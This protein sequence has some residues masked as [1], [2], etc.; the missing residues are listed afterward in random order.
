MICCFTPTVAPV[1]EMFIPLSIHLYPGS[2]KNF[3]WI[4]YLQTVSSN[5]SFANTPKCVPPSKSTLLL[6][7]NLCWEHWLFI[8]V[9]SHCALWIYSACM[10]TE[11][12]SSTLS[13][14][15]VPP[16]RRVWVLTLIVGKYLSLSSNWVRSKLCHLTL[17]F[18][19][20]MV[21]K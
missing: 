2:Q 11:I 8:L 21:N 14:H 1:M 16:A 9:A 19:S 17:E 3:N 20:L 7:S 12:C 10:H 13:V 6:E 5:R 4:I 18:W 15:Q